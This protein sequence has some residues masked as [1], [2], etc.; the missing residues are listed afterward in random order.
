LKAYNH[1]IEFSRLAVQLAVGQD[2]EQQR[3]RTDILSRLFTASTAISHFEV[4]H[5]ALIQIHDEA[6]QKACLKKLVE[7]MCESSQTTELITFPFAG[8]QSK[9]DGILRDK[10]QSTKDAIGQPGA[11]PYHKV[12]YAWRISHGD[13]RGAAEVLLDRLRKLQ[14]L[15]LGDEAA[16]EDVMDTPV[17]RQYLLLIN[18]LCCVDADEQWVLEESQDMALAR[19]SEASFARLK[20]LGEYEQSEVS[21]LTEAS[22]TA[23]SKKEDHNRVAKVD[24]TIM[25]RLTAD[26]GS[27][28]LLTLDG[29]RKQYQ[30]ELDRA[31]AIQNNQFEFVDDDDVLMATA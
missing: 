14:A 3:L 15:G 19:R 28:R 22:F 4:A 13:H 9:V 7:K 27:R 5:S 29:V 2:S 16:S 24:A 17:T 11:V 30:D 1:T 6:L 12:L 18:A 8:L 31:A 23:E 26:L 21:S 20:E 10:A 25:T